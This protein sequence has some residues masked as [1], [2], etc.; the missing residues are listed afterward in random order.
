MG[1]KKIMVVRQFYLQ[2]L[3]IFTVIH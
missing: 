3:Q 2:Y 1:K